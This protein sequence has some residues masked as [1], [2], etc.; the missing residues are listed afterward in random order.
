M[1]AARALARIERIVRSARGGG[2]SA[3]VCYGQEARQ[4]GSHILTANGLD[5]IIWWR[6]KKFRND[7]ELVD[8]V[9]SWEERFSIEHLCEYASSTPNVDLHVVLLPCEH[10]FG[11]TVVSRR[12]VAGHLRILNAC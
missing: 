9:L 12:D 7:G 6:A 11:G 10:D 1:V 2:Q 5:H 8:M 4:S 3:P